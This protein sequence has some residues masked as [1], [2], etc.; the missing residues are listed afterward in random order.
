MSAWLPAHYALPFDDTIALE[1]RARLG[2]ALA[3]IGADRRV[4][5]R[6]DLADA[7]WGA[8]LLTSELATNAFLHGRGPVSMS[9]YEDCGLLFVEMEDASTVVPAPREAGPEDD[10]GRGLALVGALGA[11]WGVDWV[12]GGKRVWVS[13]ALAAVS[14]SAAASASVF[15]DDPPTVVLRAVL[16]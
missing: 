4:S 12:P 14:S 2:D 1:A 3:E 13:I 10:G 8:E 15:D 7:A 9:V 11:D 5:G 6:Y 16:A